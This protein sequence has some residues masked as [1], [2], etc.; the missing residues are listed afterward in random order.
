VK[1][2]YPRAVEPMLDIATLYRAHYMITADKT[3]LSE[4]LTELRS[5]VALEPS[6][7][8]VRAM[9][10]VILLL[11]GKAQAAADELRMAIAEDPGLIEARQSL[12]RLVTKQ[13]RALLDQG[14]RENRQKAKR[15]AESAVS[16]QAK[17]AA[18]HLVLA[19]IYRMEKDFAPAL[20]QLEWAKLREPDAA[21]VKD[22]VAE[23]HKDLGYAYLLKGRKKEAL[24]EFEKAVRA[25]SDNVDLGQVRILLGYDEPVADGEPLDPVVEKLLREKTEE[26]RQHFVRAAELRAK[27]DLEGAAAEFRLSIRARTSAEAWVEIGRIRFDQDRMKEAEEAFRT[28]ARIKPGLAEAHLGIGNVL[29]LADNWKG[30]LLGYREFLRTSADRG[31]TPARIAVQARVDLLEKRIEENR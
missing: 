2:D 1:A 28:G 14:G 10:G 22:A 24:K 7:A 21:D 5:A 26:A 29:Y 20:E 8:R 27:G 4:A 6:N 23:F 13:A 11:A 16:F 31:E 30:A 25:E 17:L 12:C 3:F 9:H 18:P 19:D 15:A